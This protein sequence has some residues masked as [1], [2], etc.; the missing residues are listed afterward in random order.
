MPG[1]DDQPVAPVPAASPTLP[2]EPVA[3]S[4]EAV[5]PAQ[6]DQTPASAAPAADASLPAAGA[7]PTPDKPAT[8]EPVPETSLLA[9]FDAEQKAKDAPPV[10]AKPEDKKPEAEAAKPEAEPVKVDPVDYFTELKLPETIKIDDGQRQELTDAFDAL[11]VDPKLGAQKLIDLHNKQMEAF[12][13]QKDTDQWAT[14]NKVNQGW[15]EQV[16]A[17]PVLG[18]ASHK[19]AMGV[20][21]RM[22]DL[23]MSSATP[24]TPRYD[25]EKAEFD[26]F[27]ARTGAGNHPA[28]LRLLHNFGRR[29]DEAAPP[30][31]NPQP[32]R[33]IGRKPG[34]SRRDRLYS[35]SNSRA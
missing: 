11:R 23:A 2:I 13:K 18:G 24:G 34:E 30:P 31:P 16:L 33:D 17:D 29:F 10:E 35:N 9:E 20:V 27:I 32:P 3:P 4:P 15:K 7:E 5:A 28:F 25:K 6:A 26:D 12:A 22:R 21:A 14:W 8:P 1:P 19:T